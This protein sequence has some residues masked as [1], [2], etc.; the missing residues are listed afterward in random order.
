MPASWTSAASSSSI[1]WLKSR[2]RPPLIGSMIFSSETRP[3]MRSRSGSMTSPRFDDRPRLDAVERAAIVIGDD[4][5]LR[6]VDETTRQVARVRGLERGIGQTLTSAVRRDEVLE[7][8]QAFA[9]VRLDRLL[10]DFAR[11]LGHQA[12]HAGQLANLLLRAS[13]TRVGHDVDRVELPFL[14]AAFHFVE[15]RVGD[16]LGD[17]R[18]HG[19]DLVVALAVGDRAFEVLLLDLDDLVARLLGQDRLVLRNDQVL[20]ADRHARAGG[21]GEAHLLEVVQHLD[22]VLEARSSGSSAAP[23][24]AG[25]SSSACR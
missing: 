3:M 13:R 11:G 10:D 19:D 22:G 5:V 9:E 20:D 1:S 15:H 6:H 12:A 4:H 21:V 2:I 25:P 14:V 16:L 8:R 24:A 18:P 23:A 7:H 17:V